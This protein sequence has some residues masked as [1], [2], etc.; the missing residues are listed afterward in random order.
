MASQQARRGQLA[1]AR[2]RGLSQRQ[3]CGLLDIA[4]SALSYELRLPAKDAPI[5][6]AKLRAECLS[7]EWFCSRREA[8]IVI[9]PG[10]STTTLSDPTAA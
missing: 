3:A 5:I 1:L 7:L 9:G 8:A 4:R 2:A 6:E 10:G